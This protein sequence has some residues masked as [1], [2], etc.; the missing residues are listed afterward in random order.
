MVVV[1]V[2]SL[3][4]DHVEYLVLIAGMENNEI[5]EIKM[6]KSLVSFF[7]SLGV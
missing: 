3:Q 5:I 4:I 2:D 1:L 6:K 7:S